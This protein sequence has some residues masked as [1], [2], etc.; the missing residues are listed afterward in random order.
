VDYLIS[1][2]DESAFDDIESSSRPKQAAFSMQP[3]PAAKAHSQAL[4]A[5]VGQAIKLMQI[6]IISL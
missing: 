3:H 6:I 5:G 2:A 4:M 1:I